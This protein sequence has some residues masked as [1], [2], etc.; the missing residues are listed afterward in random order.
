MKKNNRVVEFGKTRSYG[1]GSFTRDPRNGNWIYKKV[2]DG[3][4]ISRSAKTQNE[5]LKKMKEAER[6]ILTSTILGKADDSDVMDQTL[7][8]SISTWLY[9][10]KRPTI[11]KSSYFDTLDTAYRNQLMDSELGRSKLKDITPYKIQIYL[12]GVCE[13]LSESTAYKSHALLSQYTKYVSGLGY[14]VTWMNTVVKPK[15]VHTVDEKRH[16]KMVLSDDQIRLLE[17]ELEKPYGRGKEGYRYG[18]MLMFL[19]WAFLRIG[20]AR[21]LRW[22]DV[23][24]TTG[25][26]TINKNL[27]EVRKRDS[28]G[29]ISGGTEKMTVLP[30]SESGYRRFKLPDKALEC[31]IKHRELYS[32][33]FAEDN[34]LIFCT[35]NGKPVSQALLN[36][37]LK[38]A[39][40]KAG[41]DLPMSL[42]D[43][44]HTG[45]SYWLRHGKNI[46]RISRA[47]GHSDVSITMRIYYNLLPD[48]LDRVFGDED[49]N[50]S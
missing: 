24:F 45:I 2:I 7:Q 37:T 27:S 43:L 15:K 36:R 49:S 18:H 44:R 11:K 1:A 46:K 30:K 47:A 10:V 5:C 50:V 23:D 29:R 12:N 39:L 26:I 20:E 28:S 16:G 8:D 34:D 13:Q 38:K 41:I 35:E 4:R 17:K 48:E 31:L 6:E 32:G 21:A 14:N 9:D 33:K 42:H 25:R 22:E 40:S 3:K 19:I